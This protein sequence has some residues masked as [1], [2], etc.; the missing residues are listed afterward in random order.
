MS[1]ST[2]VQYT[3]L[4]LRAATGQEP[5]PARQNIIGEFDERSL[6]NYYTGGRRAVRKRARA[7]MAR[8]EKR[9]LRIPE[10]HQQRSRSPAHFSAL[11]LSPLFSFSL[12]LFCSLERRRLRCRAKKVETSSRPTAS[13][14]RDYGREFIKFSFDV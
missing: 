11:F 12:S 9:K 8:I 5:G 1:K 14:F 13:E 4:Q 7:C 2:E 3:T 10:V 6:V